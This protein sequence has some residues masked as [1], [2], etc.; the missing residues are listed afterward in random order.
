MKIKL[1]ENQE[2]KLTF[3]HINGQEASLYVAMNPLTGDWMQIHKIGGEETAYSG[4]KA[5]ALSLVNNIV[6]KSKKNNLKCEVVIQN[7]TILPGGS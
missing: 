1:K 2:A 3:T 4:E 7:R 5:S 6:K